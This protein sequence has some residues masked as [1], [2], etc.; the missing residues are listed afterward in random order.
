MKKRLLYIGNN[1]SGKSKTATTIET[2]STLLQEEGYEVVS[3]SS[4]DNKLF[5]LIDMLWI[6]FKN[7]NKVDLVLIDTYSTQNF[8]Y[9]LAVAK[10]CRVFKM[11]YIPI[12]HGGNLPARLKKSPKQS[13]KLF[14][15][16]TTNIAP[17]NY[18]LEA[19]VKEGFTNITYIPNT[20]EIKNYPFLLREK[21]KAK[22]LWVRSFAE[23]YNPFLA[24]EIVE[25]LQ[26]K[27]IEVSLCM[28]GPEKDGSL[29]KCKK[30]A[31][32]K[33]L[34]ITFTGILQ[35]AAWIELSKEYDIFVNTTNFDN[36]PV[37]VIEAMAL[38]LPIISTNVGGL[39]YLIED[40]KT[41]ILLVP[42]NVQVFV[43]AIT[44]LIS[45][46]NKAAKLAK[47]AKTEVEQ[48]DWDVVKEKWDEVLG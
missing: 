18:L 6:T 45:N 17:S 47:N 7:R 10:V 15:N 46:P 5:R 38:G 13:K 19:F 21:V 29:E 2:L 1:L 28:V 34:P 8:Q 11:P 14:A 37:S 33:K 30:L 35:K 24:I 41:G 39:P 42:N 31:K 20:I 43:D 27:N 26:K 23:L 3:A 44:N 4:I 25:E 48:F 9:A 40:K 36:T 32:E 12:L 16:A 22:L